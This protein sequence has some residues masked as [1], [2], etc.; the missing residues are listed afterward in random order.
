MNNLEIDKTKIIE[1]EKIHR[2]EPLSN[3]MDITDIDALGLNR[4]TKVLML[5][6]TNQQLPESYDET[7]CLHFI[8]KE[9]G[10]YIRFYASW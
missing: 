7:G 6:N 10:K 9:K 8:Y 1:L 2:W 4:N 5:E 3:Y